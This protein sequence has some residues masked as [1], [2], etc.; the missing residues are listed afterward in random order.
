MSAQTN[1]LPWA[2]LRSMALADVLALATLPATVAAVAQAEA[3]VPA[4][5]AALRAADLLGEAARLAAFALPKREAVWWACMCA[6]AVPDAQ[7]QPADLAALEKAEAWVFRQTDENRRAAF[8]HAQE[9]GFGTADAWAGVAAFWSGDSMAPLGAVAV[10]P[11]PHL[12]GVAVA[13]SVQLSAVRLKPER[14]TPRLHL[15]LDSALDIANGGT[16]RIPP[17]PA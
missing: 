8:A 11:A 5:I 17:E 7:A 9:A 12:T 15:F 14:R 16:G 4:A 13:G 3:D 6:R 2:K 1:T 10:P